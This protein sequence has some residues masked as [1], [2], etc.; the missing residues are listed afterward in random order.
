MYLTTHASVGV[1][2]SQTIDKPL[3]VL[4][5]AVLSHFVLDFTPH[6]DEAVGDW[7]RKRPRNAFVMSGIDTGLL[8][9]MLVILYSTQSLP[10][11]AL[12]SA[13]VLGAVLPDLLS[14]VFPVLHQYTNWFFL[15]RLIHTGFD[16]LQFKQ[17]V[18]IHDWFHRVT[19]NMTKAHLSI[20]Q[21]IILQSIIV[22]VAV[23]VAIQIH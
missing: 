11:M 14:N 13:G 15:V 5:L 22:I 17:L 12:I 6:G 1:L 23:T 21:G 9:I 10:Q 4:L 19:H 2:I 8:V 3:P 20:K 16:K 18:R 7:V